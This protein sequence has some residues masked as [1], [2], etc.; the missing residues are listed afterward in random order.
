MYTFPSIHLPYFSR[1]YRHIQALYIKCM[2][3]D[4]AIFRKIHSLKMLLSFKQQI[5]RIQYV[6]IYCKCTLCRA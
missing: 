5:L 1:E 6:D 4:Q 3:C 2:E